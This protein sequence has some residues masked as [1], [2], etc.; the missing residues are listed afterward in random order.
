MAERGSEPSV[1]EILASIKKVIAEDNR[2]AVTGRGKDGIAPVATSM[3]DSEY[4]EADEDDVL[5]LTDDFAPVA[6]DAMVSDPKRDAM[7][8]S[9]EALSTFS[10]PQPASASAQSGESSLEAMV[11]D[12][13]RP[14]LAQWLDDNLPQI[15]ENMVAREIS[16]ITR[17]S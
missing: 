9:L 10:R 2:A 12:M 3:S 13:L 14:M 7:R 11:R 15:V 17:K 5:E 16:R 6:E 8:E 1:E 4:I